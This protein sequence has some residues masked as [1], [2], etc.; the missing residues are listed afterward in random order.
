MLNDRPRRVASRG[1]GAEALERNWG[2]RSAGGGSGLAAMAG[3]MFFSSAGR[4]TKPILLAER[5]V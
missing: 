5:C 4:A 2:D 3:A 1:V